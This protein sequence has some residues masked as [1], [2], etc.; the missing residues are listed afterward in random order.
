MRYILPI[1]FALVFSE[2]SW[3]RDDASRRLNLGAVLDEMDISNGGCSLQPPREFANKEG[4]YIFM[5]DFKGNSLIN[6]DGADLHLALVKTKGSDLKQ[7][8]QVGE[9]SVYSYGGEGIEVEVDYVVTAACAS[10]NASCNITHYDAILTAKRGKAR[11]TVAAK[12]VC[13]Y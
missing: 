11:K 6:L 1:T 8:G 3:T 9:R 10:G 7:R 13:A 2:N 4:K 12:A 5:S